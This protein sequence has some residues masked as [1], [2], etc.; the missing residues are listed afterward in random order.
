[1][2]YRKAPAFYY[3]KYKIFQIFADFDHISHDFDR[4]FDMDVENADIMPKKFTI[5][6]SVITC[7]EVTVLFTM[8][9]IFEIMLS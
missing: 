2:A 1:M 8:H 9:P 7:T 6:R 3:A 5:S 4:F